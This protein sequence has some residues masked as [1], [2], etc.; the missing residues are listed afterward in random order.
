MYLR[1]EAQLAPRNAIAVPQS[2]ILYDNGQA[3][4]LVI[5]DTD[6][7]RRTNVSLGL[8]SGDLVEVATGLDLNQRIVGSGAAFLQ[9]GDPV[10]LLADEPA[11]TEQ[12]QDLRGRG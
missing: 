12:T 7:V 3:Y 6:H 11:P 8:R 4:V 5:D 10:R 1:G 9:D 2:S